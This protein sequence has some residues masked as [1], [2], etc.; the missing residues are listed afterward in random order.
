[1]ATWERAT[2]ESADRVVTR[3]SDTKPG[4][5]R[6]W[7][8]DRSIWVRPRVAWLAAT[9]AWL[10]AIRLDCWASLLSAW[11]SSASRVA[12]RARA[13]SRA[14]LKS[15]ASRRTSR[16]PFFTCWL[17]LTST[18][19]MRAPSWLDTRVISPCT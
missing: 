1:M 5:R 19:S 10:P 9:S 6:V 17:S 14:S 12:R 7:A 16:S 15:S 13:R 11:T 4:L 2:R 3:S 8:R 18:S